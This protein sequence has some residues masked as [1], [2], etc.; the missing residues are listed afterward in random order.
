MKKI[1][2][3]HLLA[4]FGPFLFTGTEKQAEQMRKDKANYEREPARKRLA[5]EDEIRRN[6]PSNCLNHPAYGNEFKIKYS[7]EC[8]Y[9]VKVSKAQRRVL[10]QMLS[11]RPQT[12][13]AKELGAPMRTMQALKAEGW[14]ENIELFG[15][16]ETSGKELDSIHWQLTRIATNHKG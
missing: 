7:G 12:P 4:H 15:T 9:C 14:I 16:E 2:V 8:A 11:M 1:W 5:T 10:D 6:D 13:T 3:I